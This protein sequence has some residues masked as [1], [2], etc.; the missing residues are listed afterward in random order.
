LTIYYGEGFAEKDAEILIDQLED[1]YPD[2]EF[3]AVYGG[4]P[5]YPYL[6]SIE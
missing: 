1:L 5:L 3:E 2:L 6:F 4:Q